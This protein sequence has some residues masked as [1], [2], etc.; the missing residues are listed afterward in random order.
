M[1]IL[2]G[3][4]DIGRRRKVNQDTF[5]VLSPSAD[6]A[7][8]V[9][10][11]G[12]GGAVGG[13][14][15]SRLACDTFCASVSGLLEEIVQISG[16]VCSDAEACADLQGRLTRCIPD[17]LSDAAEAANAAVYAAAES[18]TMLQGMGTTLVA[19]LCWGDFA[20][21]VNVGDSRLY[22]V[23]DTEIRQLSHDHS[24]VQYL[25]DMGKLTV[26]EAKQSTNRNIITRAVG[27]GP[28]IDCDLI[29]IPAELV[30]S[31]TFLL[32]SDGL[33]SM[34]EDGQ[35][36]EIIRGEGS[37]EEKTDALV[38]RANEAGGTDNITA[39]LCRR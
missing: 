10:C 24:Y 2:Q 8:C 36:A 25:I 33:S 34:V 31:S 37:A 39:V 3:K 6:L 29:E 30:G 21:A 4:T 20:C 35:M 11:D 16:V 38:N 14:E 12:M 9:V 13:A 23:T 28:S 26:E 32:C 19:L 22:A 1:K 27:T 17:A 5:A 15:A 7:L 18:D